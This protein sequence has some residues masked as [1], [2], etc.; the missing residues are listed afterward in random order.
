[1]NGPF[2]FSFTYLLRCR[3]YYISFGGALSFLSACTFL[4]PCSLLSFSLSLYFLYRWIRYAG[5]TETQ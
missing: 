1:M 5:E 3:Y 4:A 2:Y